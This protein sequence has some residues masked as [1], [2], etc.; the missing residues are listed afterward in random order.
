MGFIFATNFILA[1][2]SAGYVAKELCVFSSKH[3]VIFFIIKNREIC[4]G[5]CKEH[6]K[7]C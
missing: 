6:A 4:V 7:N 3:Y 2:H 1:K 5:K